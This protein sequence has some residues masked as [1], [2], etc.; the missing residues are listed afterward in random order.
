MALI[1]GTLVAISIAVLCVVGFVAFM[2]ALAHAIPWWVIIAY[3][4]MRH[5]SSTAVSVASRP[6]VHLVALADARGRSL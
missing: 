5:A 6:K 4:A 3:Y 2:I 1:W